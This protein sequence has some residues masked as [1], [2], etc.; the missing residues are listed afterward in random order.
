VRLTLREPR[1][2]HVDSVSDAAAVHSTR[3]VLRFVWRRRSF[4]HIALGA[5]THAFVA[6]GSAAWS[7]TF[8]IR[9]HGMRTGE[10]GTWLGLI[11]GIAGGTGALVGGLLSDRL[12]R[13]DQRWHAWLVALAAI[14]NLPFALCFLLWPS[15]LPAL[16]FSI[17]AVFCSSFWPGPTL[18]MAQSLVKPRMRATASAILFFVISL[19]GLGVGPQAVGIVNDLLAPALGAQAIRYSLALFGFVNLWSAVHYLLAARTLRADLSPS[20]TF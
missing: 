5:A 17:P 10:I 11:A 9:V 6:Y 18:A 12:A 4:R 8:L 20:R 13:R 2:G 1:H 7:P 14:A 15:T 3:D 19:L 16:L